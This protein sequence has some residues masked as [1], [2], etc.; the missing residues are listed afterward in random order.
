MPKNSK[1]IISIMLLVFLLVFHA[2]NNLYFISKHPLAEGKDNYS[3]LTAFLNLSQI[4]TSGQEH[5]FYD[6]NRSLW[7]NVI[8]SVTD[9]PPFFYLSA[10]L[11]DSLVGKF[12]LFGWLYTATI[13]FLILLVSIYGIGSYMNRDTAVIAAFITSMYP[14]VFFSSR[15]FNLEL[16]AA[17]M[18]GLSIWFLLKTDLFRD[19]LFSI[20]LGLVLGLGML[21][22]QTFAVYTVGP[23]AA[24]VFFSFRRQ[25]NT[26]VSQQYINL[27]NC[28]I[29]A[30][31]VSAIFYHNKDIYLN[32]LPRSG[33]TGAVENNDIFSA[34]H[35]FYYIK[36]LQYTIGF[37]FAG[38]FLISLFAVKKIAAH[39]RVLLLLW[40][41]FPFLIFNSVKLKYAEYT[42]AYL[43]VL[44]LIS[45]SGISFIV[46]KNSRKAIV[47][48]IA[49]FGIINFYS[50]S[51]GNS[52]FFY[53]TYYF[54]DQRV[55]VISVNPVRELC[56]LT[57]V[58]SSFL[59]GHAVCADS[60]ICSKGGFASGEKT[61]LAWKSAAFSN[62]VNEKRKQID[63]LDSVIEFLDR[64][65]GK[66]GIFY[67]DTGFVFPS[68]LIRN[69]AA[70]S[71]KKNEIVVFSFAP[72]IFLSNI[73]LF[74]YMIFVT[75]SDTRWVDSV[76]FEKFIEKFNKNNFDKINVEK[77]I[78]RK[79]PALS[80]VFSLVYEI[81]F[82][83]RD[84]IDFEKAYVFQREKR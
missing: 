69:I 62:G 24:Y 35:L 84:D 71:Y 1:K 37:F 33:F 54:R 75:R 61:Q 28:C 65:P 3:H 15:H 68:Y 22:K 21:T 25:N 38:I 64:S 31:C 32:I 17:A 27:L 34:S 66:V 13:F 40:I 73:D 36:S 49:L 67:D 76:G 57:L 18:T 77:D 63:S 80:D 43:P 6:T 42:I 72:K 70:K 82:Y 45:A 11:I 60:E 14:M 81:A 78:Y 51:F 79:L 30:I 74:D 58:E 12:F 10:F 59:T 9:Y 5:L 55:R 8:F 29:L 20:L 48:I 41:I 4:I 26:A 56:P 2:V 7:K 23:L 52:V 19:K 16:A 46:H 83:S 39:M 44:A 53:S 47:I 50:L